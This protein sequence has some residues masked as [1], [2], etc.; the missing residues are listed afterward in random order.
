[1]RDRHNNNIKIGDHIRLTYYSQVTS[2]FEV[3]SIGISTVKTKLLTNA[4]YYMFTESEVNYDSYL[5]NN[6]P[7]Y[8]KNT[9]KNKNYN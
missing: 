1:M 2:I 7:E 5:I 3:C 4:G 6:C 8:L 9:N